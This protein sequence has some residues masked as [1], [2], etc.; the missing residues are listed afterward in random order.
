MTHLQRGGASGVA[1]RGSRLRHTGAM[2]R[3]EPDPSIQPPH[4]LVE[5]AR[6]QHSTFGAGRVGRVGF[7]KDVPTVWLDFDDG[8]TKA[9][10]LEFGLRHLTPGPA[11]TE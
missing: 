10:A 9:L 2:P 8:Q 4:R 6:V 7:Y 11:T 5:G 3:W 1:G